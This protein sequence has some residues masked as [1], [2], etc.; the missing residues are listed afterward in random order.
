MLFT[1][2]NQNGDVPNPVDY[3][4]KSHSEDKSLKTVNGEVVKDKDVVN[5]AT[6][7]NGVVKKNTKVLGNWPP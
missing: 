1:Q 4:S 6:D 3:H 2:G 7:D 5:D